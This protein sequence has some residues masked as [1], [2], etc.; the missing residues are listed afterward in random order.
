MQLAD[1]SE[2]YQKLVNQKPERE[3]FLLILNLFSKNWNFI[4]FNFILY[5]LLCKTFL[6]ERSFLINSYNF[7]DYYKISISKRFNDNICNSFRIIL[8]AYL[9]LN[10]AQRI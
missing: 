5:K 7:R 8:N 2:I 3:R 4:S 9:Y 6:L 1:S 10:F